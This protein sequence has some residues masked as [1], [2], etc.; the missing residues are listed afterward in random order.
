MRFP[1]LTVSAGFP[2]PAENWAELAVNLHDLL[3]ARPDTTYFVRV[4][5]NSMFHAGI[6]DGDLLVVDRAVEARNCD[7]IIA[8][9]KAGLTIKRYLLDHQTILLKAEHPS[10]P[11]LTVTPQMQFEVW[12]VVLFSIRPLHPLAQHR[13]RPS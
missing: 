11:T 10:Y 8:S 4:C 7:I 2:S 1:L 12:G 9:L 5:G 13:L 3:V 6:T